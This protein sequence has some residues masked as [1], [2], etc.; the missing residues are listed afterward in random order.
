MLY[1]LFGDTKIDALKGIMQ[2]IVL[3]IFIIY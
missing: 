1:Q 2:N 3:Y